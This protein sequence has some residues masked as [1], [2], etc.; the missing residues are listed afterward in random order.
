MFPILFSKNLQNEWYY[1]GSLDNILILEY[2]VE[3]EDLKNDGSDWNNCIHGIKSKYPDLNIKI[4]ELKEDLRF[5]NERTLYPLNWYYKNFNNLK[6]I[7][8]GLDDGLKIKNEIYYRFDFDSL[9]E[10]KEYFPNFLLLIS[11]S[12]FIISLNTYII[13]V[14]SLIKIIYNQIILKS[15]I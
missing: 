14:S 10:Y 12:A 6:H 11:L 8:F 3:E 1:G 13:E 15:L 2:L 4:H 9:I 5:F 7:N